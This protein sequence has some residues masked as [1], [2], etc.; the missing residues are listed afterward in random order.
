MATERKEVVSSEKSS[1]TD[2]P[3][4]IPSHSEKTST[5]SETNEAYNKEDEDY[6]NLNYP[7]AWKL[8]KWFIGGYSQSRMI[9][10]KKPKTMYKA[11][12]LFAG[13]ASFLG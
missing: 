9:K 8:E 3:K 6:D 5:P 4:N 11:I 1:D 7:A 13:K 2:N 10:F 12:N